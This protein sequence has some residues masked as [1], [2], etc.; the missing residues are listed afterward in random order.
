MTNLII[1]GH[2]SELPGTTFNFKRT[3]ANACTLYSYVRPGIP[4]GVGQ[5]DDIIAKIIAGNFSREITTVNASR[6]GGTPI[7]DR[8]LGAIKMTAQHAPEWNNDPLFHTG[9]QADKIVDGVTLH[10]I[11]QGDTIYLRLPVGAQQTVKLSDIISAY[12]TGQY[13]IF[14]CVCR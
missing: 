9:V 7:N 12:P 1:D 4:I 10:Q 5:S 8:L 3:A 11:T 14:W 2:G 13:N 6:I